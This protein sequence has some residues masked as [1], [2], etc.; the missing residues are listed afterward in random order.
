VAVGAGIGIPLFLLAGAAVLWS[1]WE[2]RQR[3]REHQIGVEAMSEQ[4]K[5]WRVIMEQ[6]GPNPL[7]LD[8]RCLPV[9]GDGRMI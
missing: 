2:R 3:R 1:L 6:Q 4:T 5:L 9:E 8:S 7:E